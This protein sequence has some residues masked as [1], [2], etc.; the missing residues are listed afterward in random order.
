MRFDS[1]STF[2]S[3]R[4]FILRFKETFYFILYFFSVFLILFVLFS[5]WNKG[6]SFL[7]I[8]LLSLA[9]T[10]LFGSLFLFCICFD[11][12]VKKQSHSK[13]IKTLSLI[14]VVI[15]SV[16]LLSLPFIIPFINNETNVS[17][18]SYSSDS[19]IVYITDS[20]SKYHRQGCRY[21]SSSCHEIK[22]SDAISRNY[23]ACS[24]CW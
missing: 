24:V 18:V 3:I 9:A 15:F 8:T 22:L 4:N 14:Y 2:S 20:G 17:P 1:H 23:S 11:I 6:F 12:V 13:L 19:T 10:S 21:L 16:T 5:R 7:E